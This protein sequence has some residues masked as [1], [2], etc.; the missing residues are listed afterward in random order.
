MKLVVLDGF[1]LNPGDLDWKGFAD[2]GDLTVHDRTP[3][4]AGDIIGAIGNAEIIFTNKTPLPAEVLE[5]V[6]SVRYIGVLATGYNIVDIAAAKKLGI[7]VT[8]VPSYSTDSVA[9]LTFALLLEI[10]HHAGELNDSV[11]NGQW[12]SSADFCYWNHDL[13]ELA[14]KTLGIIGF[15]RIGQRVAQIADAFGMKVIA[16]DPTFEVSGNMNVTLVSLDMLLRQSDIITL[17]CPL[18][19][20]TLG[21]INK[22][23]IAL[24]KNGVIIINTARGLLVDESDL[25]NALGTG[26]VYAAAVD[27]VSVEPVRKDNPLLTAKNIVITP[28]IAW[29]PRAARIRLMNTAVANLKAFLNGT[30]ENV[31]SK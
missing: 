7:T 30:P 15:G 1:T 9:Q 27:V 31:V 28:H 13:I 19:A 10:C 22:N 21:I 20:E 17:H 4:V 25:C 8:N 29:A 3:S 16:Y 23:S 12:S 18:T 2:I 6:P 11:K 5:N 26:K 24:M 14:G